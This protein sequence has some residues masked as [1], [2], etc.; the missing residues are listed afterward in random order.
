[1]T[2]I[3]FKEVLSKFR[4]NDEVT[5][6]DGKFGA[7]EIVYSWNGFSI[8]FSGDD[9]AVWKGKI[10]L[11]VAKNIE[12]SYDVNKY[13]IRAGGK[14]EDVPL[15]D[16]ARDDKY[17]SYVQDLNKNIND[18][19]AYKGKVREAKKD[20]DKRDDKNKYIKKYCFDTKEGFIIFLAE[21]IKY[22]KNYE[23]NIE[24]VILEVNKRIVDSPN[25]EITTNTWKKNLE[26][27][28][29][30]DESLKEVL[31]N[32]DAAINPFINNNPTDYVN[33]MPTSSLLS[34]DRDTGLNIYKFSIT[35]DKGSVKC[36]CDSRCLNYQLIYRIDEGN[37]VDIT[38]GFYLTSYDL[39]K[40]Y[41]K[42]NNF[43]VNADKSNNLVYDVFTKECKNDDGDLVIMD[44][45]KFLYMI[46]KLD[47][48][49]NYAKE[50]T[51]GNN[52]KK[53]V[54]IK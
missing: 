27:Y 23:I 48:A 53:K 8:Y 3:E 16:L 4:I 6:T 47:D 9:Y 42:I 11:F 2:R 50:I 52:V 13:G 41:I 31:N 51:L 1:M 20:L 17:V 21:I 25:L 38:H 40:E 28:C 43:G 24:D 37:C 10:P 54:K 18:Y 7:P 22:Y 26:Y 12:D 19:K 49:S 45:N 30:M 33:L 14:Y 36:L 29:K 15:S 44:S 34:L 35:S 32:F 46:S 5:I 39:V